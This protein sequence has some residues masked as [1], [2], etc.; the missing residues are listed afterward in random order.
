MAQYFCENCGRQYDEYKATHATWKCTDTRC[1]GRLL[2][3]LGESTPVLERQHRCPTCGYTASSN[4]GM[5]CV[6]E[7]HGNMVPAD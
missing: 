4:S 3:Q 2:P 7:G 1:L 6:V 5:Q